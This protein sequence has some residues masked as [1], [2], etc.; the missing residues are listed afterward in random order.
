M[1]SMIPMI[2]ESV[3]SDAVQALVKEVDLVPYVTKVLTDNDLYSP[4]LMDAI[5][6]YVNAENVSIQISTYIRMDEDWSNSGDSF[7]MQ[8]EH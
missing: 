8:F 1:K 4:V 7:E 5:M 2:A 6:D 3:V